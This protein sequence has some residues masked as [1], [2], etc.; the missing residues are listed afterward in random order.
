MKTIHYQILLV[1][2]VIWTVS[3]IAVQAQV[4]IGTN[5]A[6]N[7]GALLELAQNNDGTSNKG[8]LLPRME[9]QAVT[10]ASPLSR[11]V[12]AM[13]VTNQSSN[14]NINKDTYIN[15][16]TKWHPLG[17]LPQAS[18]PGQY[19]SL[20][21]NKNLVWRTI[22]VP[23]P[24][25]GYT[26][27]YSQSRNRQD[28]RTIQSDNSPWMPFGDTIYITP[29]HSDN[30]LIIT[31]QV[32]LNKEYNEDHTTGW[33]NYSGGIFNTTSDE[34]N[35]MD[36][37]DGTLLF[38]SFNESPR[39]FSL[40]TLHFVVEDLPGGVQ[41]LLVKF[42]RNDSRNFDGILYLGYNSMSG[43][44]DNDFNL[45]NTAASISIQYYEDKSSSII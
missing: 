28:V 35:P 18:T 34:Y 2:S 19:L 36:Y 12:E 13:M 6:P 37:R 20:D 25:P 42:K 11:H 27:M 15:D 17:Y 26:L 31:A 29:R 40:I 30:K 41:K 32:L 44:P 24:A 45:F 43:N 7:T 33:L 3:T 10:N 21:A 14:A 23:V 16:G 22:D 38:Q 5:K 9:L 1:T 39:T 8:L 4:T